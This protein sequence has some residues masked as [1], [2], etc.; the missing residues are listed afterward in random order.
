MKPGNR[1]RGQELRGRLRDYRTDS[2]PTVPNAVIEVAMARECAGFNQM[3]PRI[4]G[5]I[6]FV[7]LVIKYSLLF[8]IS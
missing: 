4:H 7:C 8:G 6:R 2:G 5:Y 1:S 3:N